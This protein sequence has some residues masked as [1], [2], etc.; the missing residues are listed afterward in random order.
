MARRARDGAA[1]VRRLGRCDEDVAVRLV[2][3]AQGI[4]TLQHGLQRIAAV[5]PAVTDTGVVVRLLIRTIRDAVIRAVALVE[6]IEQR[7]RTARIALCRQTQTLGLA[8][9]IVRAQR[10]AFHHPMH[11]YLGG[12]P[13][14]AG[15]TA[16][17]IIPVDRRFADLVGAVM[18]QRH[19]TVHT[20]RI[21][22]DIAIGAGIPQALVAHAALKLRMRARLAVALQD[23][24]DD[25]AAISVV[26][27]GRI[28][29][30]LH[31]GNIRAAH[32]LQGQRRLVAGTGGDGGRLAVDQHRHLRI[33][34]DRNL[35]VGR[36]R[37]FR[38]RLQHV[39][40]AAIGGTGRVGH[41]VDRVI[42]LFDDRLFLR[43]HRHR[44]RRCGFLLRV[45][46][47]DE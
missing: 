17:R 29:D 25:G 39:L 15:L 18:A 37:H 16:H 26:G 27:G 20:E 40:R 35:A 42:D 19:A 11:E 5:L 12:L 45:G 31:A 23:D 46:S 13:R 47:D 24:V 4:A 33:A 34:P 10:S 22:R 30:H 2:E 38:R 28:G 14:I 7:P 21:A 41:I 3:Q 9:G 1:V 44:L 32:G 43:G 8:Q 36:Y 6:H